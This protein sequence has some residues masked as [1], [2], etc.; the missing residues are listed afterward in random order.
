MTTLQDII[1]DWVLSDSKK[2]EDF[3]RWLD[4]QRFDSRDNP[5]KLEY[6]KSWK[7]QFDAEVM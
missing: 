5:E 7:R 4:K 2:K 3:K 1:S 6:W